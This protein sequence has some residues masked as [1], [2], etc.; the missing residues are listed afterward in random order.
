VVAGITPFN[1]PMVVPCWMFV[2]AAACGNTFVLKPSERTPSASIR[3][4]ELFLETGVPKGVFNVVHGDKVAV[5]ALIEHP[6]VVAL[7]SVGSTPADRGS[8][9]PQCGVTRSA[10]PI[11][12]ARP[13]PRR[14]PRNTVSRARPFRCGT[15]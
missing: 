1:F 8:I 9:S 13:A 11:G 6:D 3:L 4:A 7:S 14:D 10:E 15:P 12:S 5:D 2:M